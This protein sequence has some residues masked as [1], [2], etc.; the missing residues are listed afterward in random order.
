MNVIPNSSQ[1]LSFQPLSSRMLPQ[2]SQS[3][4]RRVR[5]PLQQSPSSPASS[6]QHVLGSVQ[7]SVVQVGAQVLGAQHSA[8]NRSSSTASL[9]PASSNT[10]VQQGFDAGTHEGAHPASPPNA[11]ETAMRPSP[12]SRSPVSLAFRFQFLQF[13]HILTPEYTFLGAW[14]PY[15]QKGSA[16][17]FPVI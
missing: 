17:R 11:G 10:F 7:P 16:H 6:P 2:P 15:R 12:L 3:S 13:S 14:S 1:P 5:R 4:N 8:V 9:S